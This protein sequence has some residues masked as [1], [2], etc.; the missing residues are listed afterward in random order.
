MQLVSHA[1]NRHR[2]LAGNHVQAGH[3]LEILQTLFLHAVAVIFLVVKAAQEILDSD[4]RPIDIV[5]CALVG[6]VDRY[7][8]E[9]LTM[10]S[11]S[12]IGS[13]VCR[14]FCC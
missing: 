5:T 11:L 12:R 3:T 13:S 6:G 10:A 4:V 2:Q 1:Y 9:W 14:W 8:C 7:A